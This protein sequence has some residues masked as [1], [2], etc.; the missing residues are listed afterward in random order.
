MTNLTKQR[1][2]SGTP[3]GGQFAPSRRADAGSLD[4]GGRQATAAFEQAQRSGSYFARRYGVD[5]DENTQ[6]TLV[7]YLVASQRRVETAGPIAN[8]NG[9]IHSTARTMAQKAMSGAERSEVRSAMMEFT[10][11]SADQSQQLGRVLTQGESDAL[12]EDIRSRQK[13]RR[14]APEG[15]HRPVRVVPLSLDDHGDAVQQDS[16]ESDDDLDAFGEGSLGELAER[17][18]DSGK[19][20][21]ARRIAWDALAEMSDAPMVTHGSMTEAQSAKARR[22]VGEVGGPGAAAEEWNQGLSRPETRDA[23]FAPFGDPDDNGRDAVV[24][25]LTQHSAFA[26]SLWEAAVLAATVQRKEAA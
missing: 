20:S 24:E 5:S 7:A 8:L 26:D 13:A 14:R 2:P 3:T 21:E 12:A 16:S 15:F 10:Q 11:M 19:K 1:I 4:L 22:L 9:Y 6:D 23:L 18:C 17:L 25:I